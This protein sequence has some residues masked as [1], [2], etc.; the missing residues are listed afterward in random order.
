MSVLKCHIDERMNATPL[1]N[2]FKKPCYS[3]FE[4]R[5]W[6]ILTQHWYPIA[7]IQDVSTTQQQVM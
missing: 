2:L 4:D 3:Q 7:R 5:D 1:I 6:G